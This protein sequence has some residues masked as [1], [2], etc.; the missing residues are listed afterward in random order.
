MR[1]LIYLCLMLPSV[2]NAGP[3]AFNC[4]GMT[5]LAGG[6]NVEVSVTL[7]KLKP[8]SKVGLANPIT[9]DIEPEVQLTILNVLKTKSGLRVFATYDQSEHGFLTFE[10][11]QRSDG[12][13]VLTDF[14][15]FEGS[16]AFGPAELK[17]DSPSGAGF[18]ALIF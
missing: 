17:C 1:T 12:K 10:F 14:K 7:S 11:R 6:Y 4:T 16:I 13:T 2:S 8:G 3:R 15:G 9:E 5:T 18:I